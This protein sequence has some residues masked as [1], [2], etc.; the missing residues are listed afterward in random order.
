MPMNVTKK[1]KS[2]NSKRAINYDNSYVSH[3]YH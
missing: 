3:N 1:H 2:K